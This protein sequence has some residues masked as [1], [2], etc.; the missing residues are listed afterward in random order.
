M[1][2]KRSYGLSN[3]KGKNPVSRTQWRRF[4]RKKKEEREVVESSS[5]KTYQNQVDDQVK[6]PLGRQLFS[7]KEIKAKGKA[8]EETPL[9]EGEME[10]VNFNSGSEDYFDVICNVVSLLLR[11]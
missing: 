6:K 11:E 8:N 7:S 2:E 10:I 4:Q 3:Y 5:N 9:K 1:S